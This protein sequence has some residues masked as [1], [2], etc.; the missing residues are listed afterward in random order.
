MKIVFDTNIWI[1]DL[2]LNSG[3][4][5][6]VRFYI[7]KTGATVVVP[8]VVRLELE[9]NFTQKL[10]DYKKNI[11]ESH[12]KLLTVFGKLKEVV[13]PTDEDIDN[14]ASEI[15][16]QLDVLVEEIP[17]SLDAA[18]SSFLKI[19]DEQPPSSKKNQQFKDGVIW[20]NCLELLNEADVCFVTEDKS[21]YKDRDY[22]KGPA[23]NLQAEADKF[24]NTLTLLPSL[25]NLLKDIQEDVIIDD[26]RL[27]EG[28][29][30]A[31]GDQ[32][33]E[34]L[35]K[36]EFS[37]G[38]S[39][40]VTKKLFLTENASQLHAVFNISYQCFDQTDKER[41]N[42]FLNLEG[43]GLYETD[44]EEFQNVSITNVLLKF[45]DTEGQEQTSGYVSASA[46]LS[47]GYKTVERS[48]R[49]PLS[50]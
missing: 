34:V 4:G 40:S 45:M 19:L 6:A 24:P 32:I 29:I 18:K 25:D 21:F 46:T 26:N 5:A 15:L 17:F 1:N 14:R 41:T 36:A 43:S 9:K 35:D 27:I 28:I 3:A 47:G 44:K 37:L 49:R 16:N 31:Q 11:I 39:P 7:K 12:N 13:L 20:A 10:R 23:L 42:A 50:V 2:G 48:V 22:L 30:E 8:E 38:N 33:Y